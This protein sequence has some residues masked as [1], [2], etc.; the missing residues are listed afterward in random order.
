MR[1]DPVHGSAELI[2]A[3]WNSPTVPV[4]PKRAVLEPRRAGAHRA[5]DWRCGAPDLDS[6]FRDFARLGVIPKRRAGWRRE[7]LDVPR[8][9]AQR[10]VGARGELDANHECRCEVHAVDRDTPPAQRAPSVIWSPNSAGDH[11]LRHLGAACTHHRYRPA[12]I[13]GCGPAEPRRRDASTRWT[14][15]SAR[16]DGTRE[17]A[18]R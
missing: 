1:R 16:Y 15:G 8:R 5:N 7:G 3:G 18:S 14:R 6:A 10:H 13:G 4:S 9:V 11:L 12:A 17:R 2:T